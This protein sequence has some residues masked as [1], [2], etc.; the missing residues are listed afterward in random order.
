MVEGESLGMDEG[1]TTRALRKV[2]AMEA[3]TGDEARS[4]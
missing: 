1:L 4:D 2:R 3:I